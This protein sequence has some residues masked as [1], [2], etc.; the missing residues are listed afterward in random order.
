MSCFSNIL[1][2]SNEFCELNTAIATLNAPTGAVGLPDINK[3]LTVH[4]LCEEQGK[5]AFILTPDEAS[6]V[7]FYENL[8]QMQEGVLLYPKREFTFLEV[9]GISREYEQ[10]RLGVLKKITEGNYT[11]VIASVGAAVQKTMPPDA[12]KERSFTITTGEEISIDETVEKLIKAGYS[13]F[14]QVDGTSQFSVRGGL[15]DIFSPGSDEPV[16]IELWGDTVDS[17]TSFDI[18]TQR[19][20][21]MVEKIDIIPATEVLFTTKEEQAKRIDALASTLKGKAIKAREKLYADS[22]KLKQGLNLHCNDKYLP[23]A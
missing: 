5:K 20:S 2:K 22:E 6:A 21:D 13:R 23:L 8:S 3:V 12:L 15:I 19:R 16:R 11:A 10:L 18:A 17:I 1:K 9:E 7:R 4:A 14:D